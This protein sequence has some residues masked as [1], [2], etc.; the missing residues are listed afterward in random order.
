MI[1]IHVISLEKLVLSLAMLAPLLSPEMSPFHCHWRFGDRFADVNW[2]RRE[3]RP[4]SE[5]VFQY[6]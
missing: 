4:R 3:N 1:H 5:N 6:K 2:Y